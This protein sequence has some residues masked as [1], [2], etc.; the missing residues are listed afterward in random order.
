M[1]SL[2]RGAQ[3]GRPY[4]L[5]K[6][7]H[8]PRPAANVA[9]LHQSTTVATATETQKYEVADSCDPLAILLRS[10]TVFLRV[11][12]WQKGRE[13]LCVPFLG[14]AV[15]RHLW[16]SAAVWLWHGQHPEMGGAPGGSTHV[17]S[18][19][20]RGGRSNAESLLDELGSARHR[21]LKRCGML[22]V[23]HGVS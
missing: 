11:Y 21:W 2:Q 8:G 12:G 13:R 4:A 16:R 7:R 22:W 10:Y 6:G 15:P 3:S 9:T 18:Q 17:D 23:Y 19:W 20:C 1:S 5:R 14:C